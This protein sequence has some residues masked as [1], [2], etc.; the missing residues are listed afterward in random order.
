MALQ[1]SVALPSI[2]V[3]LS[4][5]PLSS[6]AFAACPTPRAVVVDQCSKGGSDLQSL[7]SRGIA[8]YGAG[9]H[10]RSIAAFNEALRLGCSVGTCMANRGR[11]RIASGDL[12][13]AIADFNEVGR[14]GM[15]PNSYLA[16]A[17]YKKRE[18]DRA[19]SHAEDALRARPDNPEALY[20]RGL[21]KIGKGETQAGRS[22]LEAAQALDN[23]AKF[24][25]GSLQQWFECTHR[26]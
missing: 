16:I 11:V 25:I 22:D 19:L 3:L 20:V 13:G 7:Q 12:D 2:L 24:P 9:Q 4:L 8:C 18:F 23:K 21:A 1:A 15:K 17:Y 14:A 6:A 5:T 10:S 26:I